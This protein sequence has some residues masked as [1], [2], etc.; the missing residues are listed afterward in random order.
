MYITTVD[1][2]SFHELKQDQSLNVSFVGFMDNVVRMLKDCQAGKLELSLS[3]KDSTA[4]IENSNQSNDYLLQFV[5][6]RAFKNLVHLCLP[7]RSAP[8]HTVLFY[9]NTMLDAANKKPI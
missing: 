9:I 5:E 6:I 7:C 3:I 4:D 1:T 2:A 8:L